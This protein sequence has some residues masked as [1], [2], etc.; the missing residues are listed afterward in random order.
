MY[1]CILSFPGSLCQQFLHLPVSALLSPY[2]AWLQWVLED[3]GEHEYGEDG[4]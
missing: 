3:R 2:S 1:M 4:F